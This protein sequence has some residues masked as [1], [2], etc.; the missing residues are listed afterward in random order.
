[1]PSP[2]LEAGCRRVYNKAPVCYLKPTG[3]TSANQPA[4]E[5]PTNGKKKRAGDFRNKMIIS[6]ARPVL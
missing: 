4:A 6:K 3:R 2:Q 5:K 1:M